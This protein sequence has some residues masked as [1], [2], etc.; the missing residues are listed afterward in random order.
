M[1]NSAPP[2]GFQMALDLNLLGQIFA[3]Y[4]NQYPAGR[5]A[6]YVRAALSD[7]FKMYEEKIGNHAFNARINIAEE[8]FEKIAAVYTKIVTAQELAAEQARADGLVNAGGVVAEIVG[9][10]EYRD[11]TGQ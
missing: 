10:D 3:H 5:R 11:R 8:D 2:A 9:D 7:A 4:I 6:Q 1:N